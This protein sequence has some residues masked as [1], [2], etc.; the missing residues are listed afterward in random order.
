MNWVA[1]GTIKEENGY[2][3][4]CFSR[5][6]IKAV[7]SFS[8]EKVYLIEPFIDYAFNDFLEIENWLALKKTKTA[9]RNDAVD[10]C[11]EEIKHIKED[12]GGLSFGEIEPHLVS[13]IRDEEKTTYSINEEGISPRTLVFLLITNVIQ[14][15]LSTGKYHV[16]RGTL[17]LQG[18]DLLRVWDRSTE[19]LA[20]LGY[21]TAT[22]SQEDKNWIREQIKN[23]G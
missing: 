16:Y 9:L 21:Y 19:Q 15:I 18:Q 20:E 1:A 6:G 2:R 11:L 3:N 12:I 22:Q 5:N 17:G 13:L 8:E 4:T 7:I 10:N 14:T 23:V